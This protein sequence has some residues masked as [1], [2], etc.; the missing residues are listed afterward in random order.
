MGFNTIV[1]LGDGSNSPR[2]WIK[3]CPLLMK[4]KMLELPWKMVKEG[5]KE[6]DE[7]GMDKS[8]TKVIEN[9]GERDISNAVVASSV[10]RITVG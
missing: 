3:Q 10:W 6:P 8:F 1:K 5:N 4:W 9:A 2:G 7:V